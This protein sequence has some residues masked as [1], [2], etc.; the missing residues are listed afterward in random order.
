MSSASFASA[1][2]ERTDVDLQAD[3]PHSSI[4][5]MTP[6]PRAKDKNPEKQKLPL[7][8]YRDVAYAVE[9]PGKI[10]LTPQ[11]VYVATEDDADTWVPKLRGPIGFDLEWPFDKETDINYTTALVLRQAL[12]FPAALKQLIES[13]DIIKLGFWIANDC[14]KLM[15]DF[16]IN[17]QGCIDL[18]SLAKQVDIGN[19]QQR[20]FCLGERHGLSFDSIARLYLGKRLAKEDGVR[21]SNWSLTLS[22]EQ[23]EY[24]ANDAHC[25][26]TLL[27]KLLGIAEYKG[28]PIDYA[29]L[30]AENAKDALQRRA[31]HERETASSTLSGP[32]SL[33]EQLHI[34]GDM[35][36]QHS[37]VLLEVERF[38]N[39]IVSSCVGLK[40]ILNAEGGSF[41]GS[42]LNSVA[43]ARASK[44]L[45]GALECLPSLEAGLLSLEEQISGQG[46]SQGSLE[47]RGQL[48]DR[49]RSAVIAYQTHFEHATPIALSNTHSIT[50]EIPS[51]VQLYG[52]VQQALD[53][54]E[55][56][57]LDL[58]RDRAKL[59]QI[60]NRWITPHPISQLPPELLSYIFLFVDTRPDFKEGS[61][62]LMCA[63][64]P[65]FKSGSLPASVILSHVSTDW[66]C[67]A[68]GTASMWNWIDVRG[69]EA[70]LSRVS[71]WL[72]RSGGLPLHLHVLLEDPHHPSDI[73]NTLLPYL[74]RI[75][76]IQI[77]HK[78][79][80]GTEF[81]PL[82]ARASD[83]SA[84]YQLRVLKVHYSR[85]ISRFS[86]VLFRFAE[87][88]R[89]LFSRLDLLVLN[90]VGIFGWPNW[91]IEKVYIHLM[92]DD[93]GPTMTSYE[94]FGALLMGLPRLKE[95][96]V[97]I[98]YDLEEG[99][100]DQVLPSFAR[101]PSLSKM[102]LRTQ[103][104]TLRALFAVVDAPALNSLE[105]EW[106][107][108]LSNDTTLIPSAVTE[109]VQRHSSLQRLTVVGVGDD[110]LAEILNTFPFAPS[111]E[112]LILLN[113]HGPGSPILTNA[114][115]ALSN[116]P[117]LRH[118]NMERM[119]FS[120]EIL[121]AFLLSIRQPLSVQLHGCFVTTPNGG[122]PDTADASILSVVK[123]DM[124]AL[125]RDLSEHDITVT[126][127]QTSFGFGS[128]P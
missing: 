6:A 127:N 24:A 81:L 46:D 89:A 52:K 17:P 11:R 22:E 30:A 28:I 36:N 18:V 31:V 29:A 26:I 45:R 41:G 21:K 69:G 19:L 78:S 126:W 51:S 10:T 3:R 102:K 47:L 87:H 114:R 56:Q 63:T 7:Y 54:L 108:S 59:R 111:L 105:I 82:L 42:D 120:F 71:T 25:G 106:W 76:D 97:S 117:N 43:R 2:S 66:R 70:R 124:E 103:T 5:R 55:A 79:A 109:F 116:L 33:Q 80:T 112:T 84:T 113:S 88:E 38:A 50:N 118:L 15:H 86:G 65:F 44:A 13:P 83:P 94:A 67:I 12:A 100:P 64:P 49:V 16:D 93:L 73:V 122:Y 74:Q 115:S 34:K 75:A 96:D 40:A 72:A 68:L 37:T 57:K 123:A 128:Q 95:L 35:S 62:D 58:L 60:Q 99:T 23:L 90:R 104:S 125:A 4:P 53:A 8:S 39:H 27:K 32:R 101:F 119:Y 77:I 121:N 107:D 85:E 20:G 110:T 48:V 98:L 9:G 61:A 92:D 91:G 1:E 14:G